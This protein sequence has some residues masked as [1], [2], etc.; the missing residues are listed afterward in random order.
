MRSVSLGEM[1][2]RTR[3]IVGGGGREEK[4]VG[5][6][7]IGVAVSTTMGERDVKSAYGYGGEEM[8]ELRRLFA[9]GKVEWG[10]SGKGI[11]RSGK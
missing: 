6:E 1:E 11:N 3:A 10:V 8:E 2:G 9:D 4:R 5:D 7:Q